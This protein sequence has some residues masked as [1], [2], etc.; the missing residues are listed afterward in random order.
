ML[1]LR[2]TDRLRIWLGSPGQR[3]ATIFRRERRSVPCPTSMPRMRKSD[4]PDTQLIKVQRAAHFIKKCAASI[5]PESGGIARHII[6][7][8]A[9]DFGA[10]H[11]RKAA[12]L[13]ANIAG[14]NT[15]KT[16]TGEAGARRE[17]RSCSIEK[18]S[19][20]SHEQPDNAEDGQMRR[21]DCR[22]MCRSDLIMR[23]ITL[24]IGMRYKSFPICGGY[25]DPASVQGTERAPQAVRKTVIFTF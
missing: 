22:T 7:R 9:A 6:L 21:R 17:R 2:S 18:R 11:S 20:N 13:W 1:R 4:F 19:C 3:I 5:Y 8:T 10:Y 25:T 15:P 14:Y 12:A 23:R 24:K 16:V